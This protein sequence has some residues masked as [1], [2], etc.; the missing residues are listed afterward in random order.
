MMAV[1]MSHF[2]VI[3]GGIAGLSAANALASAGS[4]SLFLDFS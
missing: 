2:V 4:K 1:S 3:G